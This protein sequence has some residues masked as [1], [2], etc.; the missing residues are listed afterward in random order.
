MLK[1]FQMKSEKRSDFHNIPFEILD[2][3]G[4]VINFWSLLIYEWNYINLMLHLRIFDL[5]KSKKLEGHMI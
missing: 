3:D 1:P 2:I 4:D 5:A